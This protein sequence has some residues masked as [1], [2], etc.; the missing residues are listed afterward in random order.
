MKGK[1][2]LIWWAIVAGFGFLIY[3]EA[4]IYTSIIVCATMLLVE[5]MAGMIFKLTKKAEATS[6]AL[7]SQQDVIEHLMNKIKYL[8][9]H[10]DFF[11][12]DNST[13]DENKNNEPDQ[14]TIN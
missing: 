11:V 7:I 14:R 2:Y 6:D 3:K 4:G 9:D 12:D 1:Y 8:D 10:F 13:S 5:I